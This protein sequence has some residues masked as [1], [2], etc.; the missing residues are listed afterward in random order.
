MVS[1][2][3]VNMK[4]RGGPVTTALQGA[5]LI[6]GTGADPRPDATLVI[7]GP[8]LTAVGSGK[9]PPGARVVDLGGRVVIPGLFNCHVHLQLN[10][11]PTPLVDLAEEPSGLSLLLAAR[12]AG[13][14]LR[15]GV[16]TVRDCGAKDMQVI[17]L[18]RAVELDVV[19]GPRI[20]ACGRALCASGGH[21]AVLG[22]PV[23]DVAD[24]ALATGR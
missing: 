16:T 6:D 22:D 5:T 1:Y 17:H 9:A 11:G 21:A 19:E 2:H 10:A 3:P 7:D 14:M 15:A 8:T 13:E 23:E 18:R 20:L 12:R 24:V 4:K